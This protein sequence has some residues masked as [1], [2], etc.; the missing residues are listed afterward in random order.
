MERWG[1]RAPGTSAPAPAVPRGTCGAPELHSPSRGLEGCSTWNV[2]RAALKSPSPST[3]VHAPHEVP[4]TTTSRLRTPGHVKHGRSPGAGLH[5]AVMGGSNR[6]GH[7]LAGRPAR[8]RPR[9]RAVPRGTRTRGC[10]APIPRCSTW[11]TQS[12]RSRVHSAWERPAM[13]TSTRA[14]LD[15]TKALVPRGTGRGGRR[16]LQRWKARPVGPRAVYRWA[17][18]GSS[19]Q[20]L[21]PCSTWNTRPFHS[22]VG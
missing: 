11:N 15:I 4:P 22:P 7:R 8:T 5:S 2:H 19:S 18:R 9:P 21:E 3:P 1:P 12:P 13:W 17:A 20:G 6:R 10:R 14:S 16:V